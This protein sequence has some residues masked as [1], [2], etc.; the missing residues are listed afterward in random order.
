MPHS[1]KCVN[2]STR[3]PAANTAS[4]I[5]S[6]R[7]SLPERPASGRSSCWY[8]DGWLQICLS[9]VI[10]ARIWPLRGC[11]AFGELGAGDERVEHRLVQTDLL[12]RHRAV[13]ELVDLVGQLGGDLGLGLGAPEHEDAVQRAHRVLGLDACGAAVAREAGD[14]LRPGADEPGVGEV[15]DGPEVAEAVLDRRPGEREP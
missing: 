15:E 11:F 4:T 6:S 13:V 2:T 3:S 14:E 10:A 12:G 7:A 5:S 8:A 9:A 1:A